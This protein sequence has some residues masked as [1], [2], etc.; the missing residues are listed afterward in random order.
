MLDPELRIVAVSDAY[1]RATITCREEI[2][3]KSLFEVFPDNPA[4]ID[5]TGVR[6][7]HASLQRVLL[8]RTSD[9]MA[10]QKYDIRKLVE[11]GYVFEERY[12]SPSN[13]PILN[14]DGSVAWIIHRV[15]DV[16]ESV[17]LNAAGVEQSQLNNA[18]HD[19]RQA[20]VKLLEDA[21]AAR[22]ET[23]KARQALLAVN[24]RLQALLEATPVGISFSEDATCRYVT[25]NPALLAQFEMSATD[26]VSASAPDLAAAGRQVRYFHGHR[27]LSEADL[28]LQRAAA[29][30]K[31]I[32]PMVVEV[33]LP[34]GR[35]WFAE[36]SGAPVRDMH[37]NVIAGIGMVTD[38]SK[39][40]RREQAQH[41]S[42][43]RFREVIQHI[44]E[45]FWMTDL[46]K[47]HMIFIS[48]GYEKIWGRTCESLYASP[49]AWLDA[50]HPEDRA[51]VL[52]C[53][54]IM[55]AAG[56]YDEEYR[57]IRPDGTVRWVRDR[58]F[59][60]LNS[61]GVVYRMAGIADDITERKQAG[62]A[63]QEREERLRLA[64]NAS[65]MAT[66]DWHIPSGRIEWNEKHYQIMGYEPGEIVPSYQAWASRVHPED[67][68][69]T[70][71][72][73]R[74]AVEQ[75]RDYTAAFRIL[76][77]GGAIYHVEVSG[78][79]D[80][81]P[82]GDAVR[83]YGVLIDCTERV[84]GEQERR[85]L[86]HST[87]EALALLDTLQYHAPIGIAFI[88]RE[89]RYIRVN[90]ELAAINGLPVA[91]H[92]GHTAMDV[93]PELW[94]RIEA[95]YRQVIEHGEPVIEIE[96]AGETR[97]RPGEMRHWLV[98]YYPVRLEGEIA[99]IGLIVME[100]TER[101]R[102]E[103]EVL[104]ISGR[105]QRRIGQDLHDDICQ[106]LAGIQ[107][108]SSALAKDLTETSPANATRALKIA[109]N[110]GH[111][112]SRAR[113]L[114]RGLTPTV[115][116]SEGL[117]GALHELAANAEEMFHIRCFFDDAAIVEVRS[118]TVVL[119]LYRIAQEAISNAVRHGMA[120]EI[121]IRLE[122]HDEHLLLLIRDNGRAITLPLPRTAGMGLRTMRYRSGMI[123]A[124]LDIG[125][126]QLRG[127]EV[128]CT[129]SKER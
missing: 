24:Q 57:I 80:R 123:G 118:K 78:R 77:P 21:V 56:R 81:G 20:V 73:L 129:F 112:L 89:Y 85:E 100:I 45:V 25:G 126:G 96:M 69:G 116:E 40:I 17:R 8:Q 10:V 27:E 83:C 74:Q 124:T 115:I 26:N 12:W 59:P 6:N 87:A 68:P 39:R 122:E 5:A 28:P 7:L 120:D 104:D 66:W 29:T 76:W 44:E 54:L 128:A 70:E 15:E 114:A 102:L 43:E 84:Q 63:L 99:G 33:E 13:S 61:S 72:R 97:A 64:I 30:N 71:E 52:E 101:K 31:T 14:E 106:W 127:T 110:M 91:S 50:V 107:L 53:A 34:S 22:E 60:V 11:G 48:A 105:E 18:L 35:R 1:A 94:P 90:E 3:G 32:P 108:L 86:L 16:T 117:A 92:I 41:E 119:H 125:P 42:E 23:E 79:I 9:S 113:M 62:Q 38:I 58:A 65:N 111:V 36:I 2:L 95:G 55:Q 103:Q 4:D 51:R 98:S 82:A 88:D 46:E 37:G 49:R 109:E 19:S 47:H 67:L 121:F 75:G 93:V